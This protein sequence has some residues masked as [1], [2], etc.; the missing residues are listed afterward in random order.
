MS[1]STPPASCSDE[2]PNYLDKDLV[3]RFL[4]RAQNCKEPLIQESSATV[5]EADKAVVAMCEALEMTPVELRNSISCKD[6]LII[7]K[8]K[9]GSSEV[10]PSHKEEMAKWDALYEE[11]RARLN[12]LRILH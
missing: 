8:P 9:A 4:D 3:R 11:I 2:T 1:I 7:L 5:L 6:N 12:K 10:P